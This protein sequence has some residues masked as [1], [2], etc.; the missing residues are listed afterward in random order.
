MD[1]AAISECA[2]P[3]FCLPTSLLALPLLPPGGSIAPLSV[4]GSKSRERLTHSNRR[5]PTLPPLVMRSFYALLL[6]G[7]VVASAAVCGVLGQGQCRRGEGTGGGGSDA[8]LRTSFVLV[9]SSPSLAPLPF[10]FHFLSVCSLPLRCGL[11][12]RSHCARLHARP[13]LHVD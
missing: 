12:S 8:L 5:Q 6:I 9:S 2:I 1:G 3:L 4:P 10:C 7:L 13:R 11:Q